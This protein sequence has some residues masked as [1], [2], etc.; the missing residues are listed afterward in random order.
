MWNSVSCVL[1]NAWVFPTVAAD[2]VVLSVM[3]AVMLTLSS[4]SFSP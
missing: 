1:F 2:I 4:L 3:V